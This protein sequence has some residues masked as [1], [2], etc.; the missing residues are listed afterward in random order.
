MFFMLGGRRVDKLSIGLL[1]INFEGGLEVPLLLLLHCDKGRRSPVLM[2]GE[3]VTLLK[4]FLGSPN[5]SK[6]A[7][8]KSFSSRGRCPFALTT[9]STEMLTCK[10][11]IRKY[12]NTQKNENKVKNFFYNTQGPH[13]VD[14]GLRAS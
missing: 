9:K 1:M 8:L 3:P 7:S 11:V 13:M 2:P 6:T 10:G 5:G 12:Y 14:L 4:A